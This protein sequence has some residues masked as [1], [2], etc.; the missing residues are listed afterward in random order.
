MNTNVKT[1]ELPPIKII[2]FGK[3]QP[4]AGHP[5][6]KGK[7]NPKEDQTKAR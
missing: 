1:N 2:G 6:Y 3:P 5:D 4:I 7:Q